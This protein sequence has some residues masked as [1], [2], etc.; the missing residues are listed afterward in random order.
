MY[1]CGRTFGH[2]SSLIKHQRTHTAEKTYEYRDCG[3]IFSQ[4]SSLIIHYDFILERNPTNVINVGGFSVRVHLSLS[5]TGFTQERNSTNVMNVEGPLL[6]LHPLLNIR[7]AMLGKN[8][9]EFS[10][11]RKA[12]SWSYTQHQTSEIYAGERTW[13][14]SICGKTF[15][16]K[17]HLFNI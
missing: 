3:R 17:T 14:F 9:Y 13:K 2:T 5:I 8:P 1:E 12:F 10:R 4:S 11:Y 6:I 15:D 16:R 7:K